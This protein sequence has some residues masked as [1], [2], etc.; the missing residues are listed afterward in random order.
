MQEPEKYCV[1]TMKPDI[2]RWFSQ[3][4]TECLLGLVFLFVDTGF[5]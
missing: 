1:K 4:R 2:I 3:K 5:L